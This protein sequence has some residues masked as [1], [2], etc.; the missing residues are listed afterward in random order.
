[1]SAQGNKLNLLIGT[2]TNSSDSKGIYV[3]EFDTNSGSFNLKQASENIT[4]PSYLTVSSDNKFVYSVSEN[5]KQ[6]TICS[7]KYDSKSG[8]LNL[9]NSEDS[10][11]ADPCYIIND[12]INVIV[13]NYSGGNISVFGK[14]QDGSIAPAKQVIQHFGKGINVKRQESPHVHMVYFSPDKKYVLANDLGNDKVYSYS[15][16]PNSVN[17][18]LKIKDSVA[19]KSGSGPRHL[20]FSKDGKF[21]YLLQELDG[22][23][24][25]FS[26][27]NGI[28]KKIDETTILAKDFRGSFS[29]ADIHI[30]PD[31]KFLYGSNRAHESLTIFKINKKT[32][33]LTLVGHQSVNGKTPRNFAIDPTGRFIL[34]ANQDSDNITI[35][36][37]H[38]RTGKLTA[39]GKEIKVSSPVCLK[40][41]P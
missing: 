1:M 8:K 25:V 5:G 21:V 17:A 2:Y 18:P 23:L 27:S 37:R 41:I 40:L 10:K 26:Y 15:Y 35:F 9:I 39:T 7:F 29:S 38:K 31:G 12:D 19:V 28:I 4:N 20:T 24:T 16:N 13:A 22:S 6:S 33:Q 14:K 11:G 30:S 32:G 3:C 34:V 36:K